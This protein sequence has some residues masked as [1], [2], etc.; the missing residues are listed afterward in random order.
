MKIEILNTDTCITKTT[1]WIQWERFKP[2]DPPT[3]DLQTYEPIV[4]KCPDC[5]YEVAFKDKDFRKHS[6]SNF[7]NLDKN[8]VEAMDVFIKLNNLKKESFLDF[9]CPQCKK[10]TRILF[11]DGYGGKGDYGVMI[12]SVI[13]VK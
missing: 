11:S 9:N 6:R 7:S 5:D 12:E 2:T 13:K 8:T 3:S 4:Y 1:N 10:P